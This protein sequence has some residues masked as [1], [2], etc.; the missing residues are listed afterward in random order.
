MIFTAK[1]PTRGEIYCRSSL[2]NTSIDSG[3]WIKTA[4]PYKYDHIEQHD[5]YNYCDIFDNAQ[6]RYRNETSTESNL[7]KCEKFK[8]VPKYDSLIHQFELFCSR[9]YLL[10]VTQS[11]HLLGVLIGGLVANQMLKT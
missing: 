1:A 10:P 2:N 9:D 4:H 3:L 5:S 7:T 11:F 6:S 8:Q